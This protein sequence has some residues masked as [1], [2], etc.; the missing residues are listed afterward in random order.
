MSNN[1]EF[2]KDAF[3]SLIKLNDERQKR[4]A[5]QQEARE[6]KLP[7]DLSL[8]LEQWG[9]RDLPP[10]DFL[11]GEVFHTTSRCMLSAATGLGKTNLVLAI[12][13]RM[14][15]GASFLHWKA[16]RPARVLYIDGEMSRRLLK[17]R[18]FTEEQ[19]LMAEVED[20]ASARRLLYANFH[21]LNTEDI[22]DFAPLNSPEGQKCIDKLIERIGGI[23][24]LHADNIMSLISGSMK[25]EEPWAAV[26]PWTRDLSKRNIGQLWVHHANSQNE[27]YGTKTRGWQMS[28]KILLTK[29]ERPD[30]DVSFTLSFDKARERT[31]SNREDFRSV[32]IC[33]L[34]EQWQASGSSPVKKCPDG[35]RAVLDA[36]NE[37]LIASGRPHKIENGPT[38]RA[39][40]V[41]TAR[42]IHKKRYVGDGEHDRA[43]AASKAWRRNFA[44]A[45]DRTVIAGENCAGVDLV[46]VV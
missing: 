22:D 38:V 26:V 44:K 39:V 7:E 45:L 37:A 13:M 41:T 42:D 21:A 32:D 1:P 12:A 25:E 19:R 16:L 17:E 5:L 10:P 27:D 34:N 14:A 30:T 15:A 23:D 36:V 18:L 3:D 29:I 24:F 35:L 9:S 4:R 46:W 8:S 40:E 31:P 11:M 2:Y 43:D 28:N 6:I 33:L 20:P